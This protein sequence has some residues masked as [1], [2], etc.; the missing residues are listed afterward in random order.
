MI[1]LYRLEKE[2]IITKYVVVFIDS[3]FV[4]KESRFFLFL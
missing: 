1:K 3:L 2:F 4:T